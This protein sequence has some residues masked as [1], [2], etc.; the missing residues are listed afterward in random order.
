MQT[1][2]C[3]LGKIGISI[4]DSEVFITSGIF[5][6]EVEG[7]INKKFEIVYQNVEG[8]RKE[9]THFELYEDVVDFVKAN[10]WIPTTELP[11]H[12]LH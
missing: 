2:K 7:M 5:A 11:S 1:H 10:V 4:V 12:S 8:F 3:K 6:R 9:A